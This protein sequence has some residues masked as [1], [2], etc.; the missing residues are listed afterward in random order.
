M[1]VRVRLALFVAVVFTSQLIFAT[2]TISTP[3]SV[4]ICS[5]VQGQAGGSP[6]RVQA[7][8][9]AGNGSI[10][11]IQ[12]WIDGIKRMQTAGSS[13]D[14]Q[15]P[16][17]P[18]PHSLN[19]YGVQGS[20][21]YKAHRDFSTTGHE[22]A[23][24]G[25]TLDSTVSGYNVNQSSGALSPTPNSPYFAGQI[26][27]A[28]PGRSGNYIF[29]NTAEAPEP[30][31]LRYRVNS[32]GSL[33]LLG[34]ITNF[35]GDFTTTG[36]QLAT[37]TLGDYMY[38]D[39]QQPS[40]LPQKIGSLKVN[41][42]GTLTLL[43]SNTYTINGHN[44]QPDV[45][46]VDPKN[47]FVFAFFPYDIDS[48][49]AQ[50]DGPHFA[51]IHRD[52]DNTLGTFAGTPVSTGTCTSQNTPTLAVYPTGDY[53][54]LNCAG[55][56][57]GAGFTGIQVYRVNRGSGQLTMVSSY[58][59]AAVRHAAIDWSGKF[60]F[61]IHEKNNTLEMLKFDAN[62]GTLLPTA[63]PLYPTGSQPS[64]VAVDLADKFVY[65]TNGGHCYPKQISN[66]NCT[67]SSSAN[68]NAYKLDRAA[69]TLT[70][71]TGQPFPSG[72]GTRAMLIFVH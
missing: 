16:V 28:A 5:P 26:T 71:V 35:G 18:G 65:V 58:A 31:I 3:A 44:A 7:M 23:Y 52:S 60:L 49:G 61:A 15:I 12:I 4:V 6:V 47:K 70:P 39:G 42:D 30:G 51:A 29:Y 11:N 57:N 67:D 34:P 38:V 43:A 33:T 56:F 59:T 68:V 54:F 21:T 19:V 40:G 63:S 37:T 32:D 20:N 53:V 48:S 17:A 22:F 1:S 55:D 69:G 50:A 8:A 45:L 13:I 72:A 24:A 27:Y 41:S 46:T 9:A 10:S 64:S 66:G 36:G 2:C 14:V 62:T 25:N